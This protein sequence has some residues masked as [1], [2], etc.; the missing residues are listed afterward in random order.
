V[1]ISGDEPLPPLPLVPQ[2]RGRGFDPRFARPSLDFDA[3][4]VVYPGPGAPAPVQP[5]AAS[6]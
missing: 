1:A 5:P 6:E 2:M 4:R 3:P